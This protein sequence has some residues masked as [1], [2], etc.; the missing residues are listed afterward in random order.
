MKWLLFF[1][2][3]CSS[4]SKPV[5]QKTPVPAEDARLLPALPKPEPV[6][7]LKFAAV[8]VCVRCHQANEF[9]MRD[10][11][12]RDVSPVTELQAGMMSLSARDPYFLAA[13]RREIDANPPAKAK[14]EAICLRCHA[15][16][17]FAEAP[18]TLEELTSGAAPNAILAREGVGCAGCHSLE[19]RALP[20]HV[21]LRTDRVS[22][23]A[24]PAPLEDAM[25]QMSRTKPVGSPHVEDSKLCGACHTVIVPRLGGGE[26]IEQAT[27][28][29]WLN[30]DFATTARAATCQDCHMPRGEDELDRNA[31]PIRTAFSTRPVDSPPRPDYRRHTLRGGNTYMLQQMAKHAAWLGAAATSSQL[32]AAAEATSRFLT[33]AATLSVVGV[34]QELRVTVINESGHK[35]PTGYPTRRM[36]LRVRATDR[37]DRVVYESGGVKA[38]AIVDSDGTRLDPVGAIMPHVDRASAGEVPIWEAVPVDDA[39]KRTHLLLGTAGFVK[40]NRILPAGWRS[41]HAEGARTAAIGVDGDSDFL[42]GRDSVMYILP[43][44]AT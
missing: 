29:E 41:D 32:M 16:V 15:P 11:R 20:A 43:A 40:D 9:D 13:L 5:P 12:K 26:I 31:R 37:E 21:I 42:P 36:W 38:G 4:P 3:A 23:G 19:P 39:G 35:L 8:T 27:Y 34:G 28:L 14:I 6:D 44:T 24:L 10:S 1:A 22:F 2:V 18:L 17:G 25:L 30:S 33:S 7:T